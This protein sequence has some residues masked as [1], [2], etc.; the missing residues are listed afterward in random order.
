MARQYMSYNIYYFRPNG[1]F[2]LTFLAFFWKNK[3]KV[4]EHVKSQNM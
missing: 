3:K 1:I 4:W 2:F